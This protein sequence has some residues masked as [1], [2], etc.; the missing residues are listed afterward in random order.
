M[1]FAS[2]PA[3]INP[4]QAPSVSDGFG[5]GVESSARLQTA[6]FASSLPRNCLI[7][8]FSRKRVAA[9]AMRHSSPDGSNRRVFTKASGRQKFLAQDLLY[10]L[11]IPPAPLNRGSWNAKMP[12]PLRYGHIEPFKLKPDIIAPIV[13]L[14]NPPSPLTVILGIWAVVVDALNGHSM[15][16]VAHILVK[17][18]KALPLFADRYAASTIISVGVVSGVCAARKDSGP[19]FINLGLGHSVFQ[20]GHHVLANLTGGHHIR[21]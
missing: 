18:L 12:S 2:G 20:C 5:F 10:G 16:T 14:L 15:R 17:S 1:L 7:E 19:D 9:S 4:F 21:I 3:R 6:C 11:F 8:I 13:S